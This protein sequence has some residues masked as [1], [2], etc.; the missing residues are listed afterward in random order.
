MQNSR[1][2]TRTSM[3]QAQLCGVQSFSYL[4]CGFRLSVL[5]DGNGYPLPETRWIFALL[6]Y[7]FGSISLLMSL[8]MGSNGNPTGTWAWVCSTTTHTRK[9]ISF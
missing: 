8:L 9:P 5:R 3:V 1:Q 6:G 7:E 2:L 4:S